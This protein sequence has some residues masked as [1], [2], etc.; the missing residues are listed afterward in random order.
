EAGREE[1]SLPGRVG[2]ELG[3]RGGRGDGGAGQR[4]RR[5]RALAPGRCL[6]CPAKDVGEPAGQTRGGSTEGVEITTLL[7][8][9]MCWRGGLG[10]LCVYVSV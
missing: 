1:P 10:L 3:A 2:R 7:Q 4:R 8:G 6:R 5:K 9:I